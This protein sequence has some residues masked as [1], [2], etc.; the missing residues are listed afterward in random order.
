V[1][2]LNPHSPYPVGLA[3]CDIER[4]SCP[5]RD[6]VLQDNKWLSLAHTNFSFHFKRGY[7]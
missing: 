5:A 6:K 2:R 4:S 3:H 7:L 1:G